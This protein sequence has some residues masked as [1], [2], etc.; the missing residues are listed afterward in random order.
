MCHFIW[1][2][3]RVLPHCVC[4]AYL[5]IALVQQLPSKVESEYYCEVFITIVCETGDCI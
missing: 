3:E 5:I 1:S 2:I 4:V